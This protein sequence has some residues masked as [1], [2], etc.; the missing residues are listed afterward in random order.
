MTYSQFIF[1]ITG[2]IALSA[3]LLAWFVIDM[4]TVSME[5]YRASFTA[6]AKFQ[7][8]EFFLF[9]DARKLFAANLAI[10]ALGGVL[11]WVF[12]GSVFVAIPVF[13]ALALMAWTNSRITVR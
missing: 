9:I 3:G 8:Q 13:F 10:M 12:T 2:V 7:V 4:G 6:R 1:A 5:R 11:T